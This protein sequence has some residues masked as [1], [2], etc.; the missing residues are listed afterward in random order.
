[1][2]ERDRLSN[3]GSIRAATLDRSLDDVVDDIEG[4][5][6]RHLPPFTALL[7]RTMNS[8]YRVVITRGPEVYVQGG[9]YFPN[10]T[11]AYLDGAVITGQCLKVGWIGVGLMVQIRSGG[12]SIITSRVCAISVCAVTAEP[13]SAHQGGRP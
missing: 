5:Y 8:V 13:P 11:S 1:V 7:V 3:T 12:R 10:P 2:H 9:A 4:V 6:L